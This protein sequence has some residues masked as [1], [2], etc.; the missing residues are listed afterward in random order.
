M[1]NE[2][3]NWGPNARTYDPPKQPE[4]FIPNLPLRGKST[5]NDSYSKQMRGQRAE[6]MAPRRG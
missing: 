4:T 5:Y 1:K 6:S 3:V 2:F